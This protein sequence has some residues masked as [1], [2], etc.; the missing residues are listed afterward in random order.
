MSL[1]A[2][3]SSSSSP[4]SSSS[5]ASASLTALRPSHDR[6]IALHSR[7]EQGAW[8][9][10]FT[11]IQLADT[12]LGMLASFGA[13]AAPVLPLS[14][15]TEAEQWALELDMVARAVEYINRMIMST[16]EF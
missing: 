6:G 5:S 9:G 15:T 13:K 12:Q 2:S 16:F 8:T 1:A 7:A 11:F 14:A 10:D 3:D 4:S